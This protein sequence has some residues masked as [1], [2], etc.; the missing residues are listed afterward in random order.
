M[1]VN[2]QFFTLTP[3]GDGMFSH[4]LRALGTDDLDSLTLDKE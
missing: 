4:L 2:G 3:H 1:K